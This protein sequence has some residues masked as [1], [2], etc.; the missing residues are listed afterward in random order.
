MTGHSSRTGCTNCNCLW[1]GR[2]IARSAIGRYPMLPFKLG[3]S[4]EGFLGLSP[5]TSVLPGGG[6][7]REGLARRSS[8]RYRTATLDAVH[9]LGRRD[10]DTP[11]R[12]SATWRG[13]NVSPKGEAASARPRRA[14]SR[15]A[16]TDRGRGATPP[17]C[18]A[19]ATLRFTRSPVRS[20]ASTMGGAP[21]FAAFSISFR[22]RG[23]PA[24]L[25][26]GTSVRDVCR[27]HLAP[28]WR[29]AGHR[30]SRARRAR[31][32]SRQRSTFR[33]RRAGKPVD[34]SARLASTLLLMS[35]SLKVTLDVAEASLGGRGAEGGAPAGCASAARSVLRA[36]RW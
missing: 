7:S 14:A 13:R 26:L 18:L 29:R 22:A 12:P 25:A 27:R 28:G 32:A 3:S 17:G 1:Y 33:R 35:S 10:G 2:S 6:T 30:D 23:A 21:Y 15:T 36:R 34:S 20:A 5:N 8:R 19:S 4:S 31:R 9:D 16:R 24:P 11:S